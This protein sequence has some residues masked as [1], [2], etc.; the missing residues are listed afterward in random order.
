M[1]EKGA[2]GDLSLW[3]QP[4]KERKL[5]IVGIST[6]NHLESYFRAKQIINIST[7]SQKWSQC[8]EKLWHSEEQK[9]PRTK[10]NDK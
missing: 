5:A 6:N 2:E 9:K 8:S 1:E 7:I 4:A 3:L 10:V